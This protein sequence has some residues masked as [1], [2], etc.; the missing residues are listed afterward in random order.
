MFQR[1]KNDELWETVLGCVIIFSNLLLIHS[2]FLE[3]L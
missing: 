2:R 1:E 3:I